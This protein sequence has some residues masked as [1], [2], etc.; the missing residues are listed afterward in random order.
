MTYKVTVCLWHIYES[1]ICCQRTNTQFLWNVSGTGGN[2]KDQARI[3]PESTDNMAIL[4]LEHEQSWGRQRGV[5]HW[6]MHTWH[7]SQGDWQKQQAWSFPKVIFKSQFCWIR[8]NQ[9]KT[10]PAGSGAPV[11]QALSLPLRK[12]TLEIPAFMAMLFLLHKDNRYS[13]HHRC[14]EA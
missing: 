12:M 5:F 1:G 4:D 8:L 7:S 13:I 6:S 3:I 11:N 10:R 2:T 9:T 14:S